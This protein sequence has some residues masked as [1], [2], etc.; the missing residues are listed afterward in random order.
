MGIETMV[1]SRSIEV[2]PWTSTN[3]SY[4]DAVENLYE[5]AAHGGTGCVVWIRDDPDCTAVLPCVSEDDE[6]SSA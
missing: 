1:K 2:F 5:S 3:N 6:M 4:F